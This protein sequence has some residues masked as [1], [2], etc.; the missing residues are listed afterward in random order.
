MGIVNIPSP[1]FFGRPLGTAGYF[2]LTLVF[3]ALAVLTS[4]YFSRTWG[5]WP[6]KPPA[7]TRRRPPAWPGS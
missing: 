2:G 7:R 3:V 5:G 1:T 4:L 6:W